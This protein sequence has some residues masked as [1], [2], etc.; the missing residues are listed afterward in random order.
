MRLPVSQDTFFCYLY[1][2]L[3]KHRGKQT[4]F[5]ELTLGPLVQQHRKVV[6]SPLGGVT[7][8]QWALFIRQFQDNTCM[9]AQDCLPRNLHVYIS[10]G[11][12]GIPFN[13]I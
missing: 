11:Y 6:G 3:I 8:F 9:G 5:P 10:T 7:G 4:C 12:F 13:G 2:Y 1:M